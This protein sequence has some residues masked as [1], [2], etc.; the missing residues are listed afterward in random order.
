M[1]DTTTANVGITNQEIFA[2]IRKGVSMGTTT[3]FSNKDTGEFYNPQDCIG[4]IEDY[5]TKVESHRPDLKKFFDV[6]R[7]YAND[8]SL[9][10]HTAL[11][12]IG[13]RIPDAPHA[14]VK[15]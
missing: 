11:D 1:T 13:Q 9:D 15:A 5:I 7:D 8:E 12:L 14:A 2:V 6:I 4:W 10:G 3:E